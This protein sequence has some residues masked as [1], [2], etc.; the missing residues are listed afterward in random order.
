MRVN[1]QPWDQTSQ[2]RLLVRKGGGGE[3]Q[4]WLQ[5]AQDPSQPQCFPVP[6]ARAAYLSHG[7]HKLACPGVPRTAAAPREDH[8]VMEQGDQKSQYHR[9]PSPPIFLAQSPRPWL[10]TPSSLD[11]NSQST[12]RGQDLWSQK[13]DCP[14]GPEES[15]EFSQGRLWARS[16]DSTASH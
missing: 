13:H 12:S 2:M 7:P 8:P 6:L 11:L 15:Q 4:P 9:A 16:R 3:T 14:G 5:G 1:K 10:V